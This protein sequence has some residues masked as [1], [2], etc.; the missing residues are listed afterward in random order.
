MGTVT[1]LKAWPKRQQPKPAATAAK[2]EGKE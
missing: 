1:R 2:A